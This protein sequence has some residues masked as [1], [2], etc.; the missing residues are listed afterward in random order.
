MTGRLTAG[1]RSTARRYPDGLTA[2][3]LN[4]YLDDVADVRYA[5]GADHDGFTFADLAYRGSRNA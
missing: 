4:A 3:A 2:E 1:A 5:D